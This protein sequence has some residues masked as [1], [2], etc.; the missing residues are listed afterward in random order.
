MGIKMMYQDQ[1]STMMLKRMQELNGA[2]VA[3]KGRK[4]RIRGSQVI[5]GN[6]LLIT[7]RSW[8]I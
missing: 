3:A 1:D 8:R 4:L 5:Y 7:D 2:L 6:D